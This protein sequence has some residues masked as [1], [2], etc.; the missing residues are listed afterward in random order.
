MRWPDDF[1]SLLTIHYSLFQRPHFSTADSNH[2][3]NVVDNWCI[4]LILFLM[5]SL[6]LEEFRSP[7]AS[8]IPSPTP[9][10]ICLRV[11]SH[12]HP[13]PLFRKNII[14]KDLFGGVCKICDP[15]GL[16]R[17]QAIKQPRNPIAPKPRFVLLLTAHPKSA[18]KK[19]RK[20]NLFLR[21]HP[22]LWIPRGTGATIGLPPSMHYAPATIHHHFYVYTPPHASNSFC[23]PHGALGAFHD[24]GCDSCGDAGHAACTARPN[25]RPRATRADFQRLSLQQ[26]AGL[27]CGSR[28]AQS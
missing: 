9:F 22:N 25:P 27:R 6:S 28:R 12:P 1:Y 11:D 4:I 23:N 2:T 17:N 18:H 19:S 5:F 7:N 16:T 3:K 14:P 24:V 10:P 15:K 26:Y 13:S 20:P 8:T 21:L